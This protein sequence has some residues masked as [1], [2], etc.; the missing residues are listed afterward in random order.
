MAAY[1]D[2]WL[3]NKRCKPR[4]MTRKELERYGAR[5]AAQARQRDGG[6]C[7]GAVVHRVEP[8]LSGHAT[9][10][11]RLSLCHSYDVRG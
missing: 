6:L 4:L 5:K 11:Y 8:W 10:Y 1:G 2:G 7:W 9:P 3:L